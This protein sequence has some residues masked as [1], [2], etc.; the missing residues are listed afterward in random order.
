MLLPLTASGKAGEIAKS[1]KEAGELALFDTKDPGFVLGFKDTRGTSAGA[2]AAATQAISEGAEL[3]IGPLFAGSVRAAAPVA[4]ARAVPVVAFSTDRNVA[5]NGV[6]LL[7]FLPKQDVERIVD[8]AIKR[9][10]RRFAALIPRS[11]YGNVVAKAFQ[12]AVASRRGRIVAME[13]YTRTA[14][15]VGEPVNKVIAATK[16]GRLKA[17]AIFIPEGGQLLR[18]I[19]TAMTENGLDKSKTQL[20]GT[21]LWD[22]PSIGTATALSGGWFAAPT[23]QAKQNFVNRYRT[24]YGRQPPRIASLAYDAVSLAVALSRNAPQGQRF[25]PERL[26]NSDGF[27]GVD[28]LFRLVP[29]GLNQRGLAI[30][31]VTPTGAKVID[32]A[33]VQFGQGNA[34]F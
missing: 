10:I 15:G 1:L 21:G 20:I 26:T 6:Y 24:A 2:Q 14:Q 22:E 19:G 23:P 12:D 18:A 8:F 3:I 16:T 27:A 17:Q 30:M 11:A 31:E 4:Q 5:G 7:S 9:K 28:G 29:E 33:P 13:R 34:A 32:Q 25:V